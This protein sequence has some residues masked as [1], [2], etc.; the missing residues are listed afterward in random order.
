MKVNNKA[1][2]TLSISNLLLSSVFIPYTII[3]RVWNLKANV[4]VL[5]CIEHLKDTF[6]YVNVLIILLLSIERY[7]AVCKPHYYKKLELNVDRIIWVVFLF[8]V[9]LSATN[10][11]VTVKSKQGS[12][13]SFSSYFNI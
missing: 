9:S 3:Y 5:K 13:S 8:G 7:V 10:Y 1:I 12:S 6:I 11:F 4:L 2:F